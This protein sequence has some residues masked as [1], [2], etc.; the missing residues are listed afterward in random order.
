MKKITCFALAALALLACQ[1]EVDVP[2]DSNASR[3]LVT[4][5]A[6]LDAEA[7]TTYDDNGK[8]YWYKGDKIQVLTPDGTG[9]KRAMTLTADESGTEVQFSA[10][11]QHEGTT[12][13]DEAAYGLEFAW[14]QQAWVL[15][16]KVT[17]NPER[18]LSSLPLFGAKDVSGLFQFRTATGVLKF[19]VENVPAETWCVSLETLGEDA[20]A[21]CGTL[22]TAPANG[23]VTMEALAGGGKILLSVGVPS[24]PNTTKEYYFFVPEGTL[25]AQKTQFSVVDGWGE[26]IKSFVF[27]KDV[28]VKANRITNIAP[29]HFKPFKESSRQIDSLALVAIYNASDGANWAKNKWELDKPIDTWPAVTVTDGRVTALKLSTANVITKEWTLPA[30][31]GDLTELTDLRINSNKLTG[32]LPESLYDLTKLENLYFQND[33][34]T[35]ALSSKIGQLTEL[36][37][38]YVDRNANMTGGIPP[39]IGQLKKLARINISQ[40][41]IGGAIPAEL[42]QCESLLQFMAFKTNLSGTLPDIWDMPVLQTVMLHTNP[43]ITGPLPS[44]LSK[45]KP[46]VNG[47]STTPPSIQI[48]SCN[49]TGSIPASF[50]NLP[51]GTKQVYV[52][53]NKMTGTIP[54]VVAA[55]PNFANWRWDPQQEGYGLTI[56]PAPSR[57]LDSLALVAI[58]NASDGPNWAKNKW[59]LDKPIDTWS[60]VTV[61]DGRVTALKLSTAN[62]IT[63]EWTLPTEIGDLTELTDLRINSNKLTGDLPESLYDLTKLE[64]LYFQNDN[65]TGALSSKI[66]QLTEL[67]QLYVDRNANMTGGIPKEIGNLKKL[68]RINISQTGIGGA[69]PAELGQCES[70]LQFM[71]FKTNLSGTLPDIWDMPVLQTVMLYGSPGLTGD[72]PASLGKLKPLENGSTVTAP[73]LQLQQCN[74]TGNIPESFAGLHEKTKQVYVQENKMSGVIPAAVAAHPNFASWKISPQQ[75]GYELKTE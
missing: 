56:A 54:A 38:L 37:Q 18:P 1:R 63:T 25:P 59:E 47:S 21:L 2:Q 65:L 50:A 51:D 30:E 62:V 67:V 9:G 15:P 53:D 58:Y 70:L 34:L 55:H 39:E 12:I 71:A 52:N 8:F 13:L 44:S 4:V 35:G 45:L 43:G 32:D 28:E 10:F 42:G 20:P 40:T 29:V 60:A 48:Y 6:R 16:E 27:Q 68:S 57:Q 14:D 19:T 22:E 49:L 41:G 64:N 5:T 24:G 75:E 3:H 31:I 36:V 11:I 69:I 33:N 46:L 73:S 26:V 66:G 23:V 72:L 7:R 17:V 61:T 74:F